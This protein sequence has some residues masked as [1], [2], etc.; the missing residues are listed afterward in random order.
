MAKEFLSEAFR[1]LDILGE[2]IF[3]MDDE[4]IKN[5]KKFEEE[6]PQL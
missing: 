1:K 6:R 3:N 2:D 4:G 5:L